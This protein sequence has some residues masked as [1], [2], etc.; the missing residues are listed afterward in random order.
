MASDQFQLTAIPFNPK[1]EQFRLWKLKVQS[2]LKSFHLSDEIDAE[3]PAD[4]DK[5]IKVK[6]FLLLSIDSET[7]SSLTNLEDVTAHILWS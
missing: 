5:N 7:L 3:K 2:Y 6:T 1:I 4:T